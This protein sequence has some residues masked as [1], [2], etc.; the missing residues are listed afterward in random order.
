MKNEKYVFIGSKSVPL[1]CFYFLCLV[2]VTCRCSSSSEST[3]K[4]SS[5]PHNSEIVIFNS[6]VQ[7]NKNNSFNNETENLS[8]Y[9]RKLFLS[10]VNEKAKRESDFIKSENLFPPEDNIKN[11]NFSIHDTQRENDVFENFITP[12][13]SHFQSFSKRKSNLLKVERWHLRITKE[14]EKVTTK[15]A[16][17][18]KDISTEVSSSKYG[19]STLLELPRRHSHWLVPERRITFSGDISSIE[20]KNIDTFK[21]WEGFRI[22][23]C[24]FYCILNS[25]I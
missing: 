12:F 2:L 23:K 15:I 1:L 10:S 19:K 16:K 4:I 22:G 17:T 18:P 11:S 21:S 5:L 25:F 20:E 9:R 3:K 14:R 6:S 24:Y 13:H 8:Q 7:V